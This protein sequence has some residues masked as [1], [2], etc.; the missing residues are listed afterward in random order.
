[1][2]FSTEVSPADVAAR[3]AAELATDAA[4]VVA[5]YDAALTRRMPRPRVANPAKY[6]P[7]RIKWSSK[8]VVLVTGGAKGITAECAFAF[9]QATGCRMALVGSSPMPASGEANE[10]TR[11]LDRFQAAGLTACY[12]QCDVADPHALNAL[13]AKVRHKL[14]PITGVIHGAA[15]NKPRRVEQ[16]RADEAMREIA[17]KLLGAL[18]LCRALRDAP[19]KLFFG[20]SSIIGV[21]GMAGNAWYGFSNEALN[22]VLARFRESHPRAAV[23]LA[24]FSVWGEA[25][26]GV[27]LG[28]TDTLARMGIG[29]IPTCDGVAHFLRLVLNDPGERQVIVTARAA[30]L[31]TW[32]ARAVCQPTG[33]AIL[34]T[35]GLLLSRRRSGLPRAPHP[36]PR[37][38]PPRP[39]LAWFLPVPDCV[40]S[41]SDGP[42]RRLGHRRIRLQPYPHRRHPPRTPHC[43]QSRLRRGHR[44]P[45]RGGRRNTGPC[46]LLDRRRADRV[47]RAT[48]LR[49]VRSPAPV[50][51]AGQ[52]CQSS[53]A[54]ARH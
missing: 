18:N 39:L 3:V 49:R 19:L 13:V 52:A 50:V 6:K 42:S 45:R 30:G 7:R 37:C 25:G 1:V 9:A 34:G 5:G 44:N 54:A 10:I 22:L 32:A 51:S 12:Y 31:D 40:R 4:V 36:R 15:V 24:A 28:S 14:G 20:F 47:Q 53:A 38:L 17:P 2:D 21:T 8:D 33:L 41:G 16:V 11:T 26:M 48:L 29:A 23:Q 35:D 43:R 27:R 46:P